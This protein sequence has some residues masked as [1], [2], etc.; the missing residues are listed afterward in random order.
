MLVYEDYKVYGP[1]FR[2]DGRQHVV[3]VHKENKSRKTV[4]YPKYLYE[5]HFNTYLGPNDTV[6]HHDR[7]FNNNKIDNLI[8]RNRR[9]H[10]KLDSVR[11]TPQEFTCPECNSVF[12]LAGRKLHDAKHN[13]VKGKSGP[14]CGRSCAGSY[15]T[16]IQKGEDRAPIAKVKIEKYYITKLK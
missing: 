3:L 8:V 4:S 9:E 16:K 14:F 10:I 12:V 11:N 5:I 13:R 7:N 1:Y 15:G 2:K 6:D